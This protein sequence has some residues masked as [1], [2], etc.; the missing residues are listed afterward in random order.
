MTDCLNPIDTWLCGKVYCKRDGLLSPHMVFSPTEALKFFIN[1]YGDTPVA[2]QA[3]KD[4]RISQPCGKC[5]S[6]SIRKRKEM[7]VRLAHECSMFENAVFLTLTY[8]EYNVPVTDKTFSI[9]NDL[10]DF[11][12]G[13]DVDIA[14]NESIWDRTLSVADV[15]KFLKRVRRHLEYVPKSA[16]LRAGRDH[17]TTRL[18]YFACGEYG[19][20]SRRPHYHI[21]IFGWKPSDLE[22]FKL[23]NGNV[24]YVSK[25][26]Q[27]LWPYGHISCSDVN[28]AVAQYA[29][30]YVTKKL[31]TQEKR[32]WVIPE[33][34]LS[35][36][37]DGGIGAS[38]WRSFGRHAC[39]SNLCTIRAKSGDVV[40]VSL[41]K[42]YLY[43]LR[44]NDLILFK[45][46]RN[47]RIAYAKV[48]KT[49]SRDFSDIARSVEVSQ[50]HDN[51][52][53]Y[54]EVF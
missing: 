23:H 47:S 44:K 6:C 45:K 13:K 5:A 36:K 51:Q 11:W 41:P 3:W 43:L 53:A 1:I 22:P 16:S 21:I 49:Q 8:D 26:I 15:Q 38:W 34:T 24:V 40:R 25:Q 30:R 48:H 52:L 39:E 32:H 37:R 28:T 9:G 10:K 31:A 7:S 42:Y 19:T 17:L 54:Y 2:R 46:V 29:A 18:R 27:K 12:R 33:F 14:R 50:Y 4:A 20:L 35:S